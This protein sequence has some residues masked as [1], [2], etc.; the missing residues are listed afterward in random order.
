MTFHGQ[1]VQQSRSGEQRVVSGRQ[2]TGQND[3]VDDT[4]CSFGSSHLEDNG[5]GR[6][7]CFLGVEV[8]VVVG[9]IEA[10]EEDGEDTGTC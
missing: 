7:T 5:K 4:A 1:S 3:G 2:D 8:G 9:D 10:N 6:G